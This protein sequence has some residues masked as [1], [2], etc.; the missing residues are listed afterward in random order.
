[1]T[2]LKRGARLWAVSIAGKEALVLANSGRFKWGNGW[3][4]AFFFCFRSEGGFGVF[5]SSPAHPF[6]SGILRTAKANA[7]KDRKLS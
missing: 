5:S 6:R 7:G 4:P 2:G 1:M 3:P